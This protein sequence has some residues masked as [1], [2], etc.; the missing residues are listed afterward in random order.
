MMKLKIQETD[1]HRGGGGEAWQKHPVLGAGQYRPPTTELKGQVRLFER[2]RTLY[3]LGFVTALA[4]CTKAWQFSLAVLA[5]D[6]APCTQARVIN[7]EW[8]PGT[9]EEQVPIP[10]CSARTCTHPGSGE[11]SGRLHQRS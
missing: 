4:F 11:T 2:S 6:W 3:L 7:D 9:E 10:V 8:C 5:G 1:G